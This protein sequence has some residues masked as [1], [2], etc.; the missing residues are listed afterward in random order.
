[1]SV[2]ARVTWIQRPRTVRELFQIGVE[3]EVP[4]NIW[5]IAFPPADWF[6]FPESTPS[7][8]IPAPPEN[9]AALPPVAEWLAEEPAK[10]REVEA[11]EDNVRMLPLPGGDAS[12]QLSRQVARLVVEA[13]QQVQS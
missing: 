4:G 10:R 8:E 1:R 12:L 9:V 11:P 2:R 7:L 5:S 3:L 6:P 13:K